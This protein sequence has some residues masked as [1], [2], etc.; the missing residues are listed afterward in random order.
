MKLF[1]VLLASSALWAQNIPSVWLTPPAP[2]PKPPA[3]VA[4]KAGR[5][6]DS[7]TGTMLRNQVILLRGER[8]TDVGPSVAIPAGAQVIDLSTA[9]VLPGLID[10]HLHVMDGGAPVEAY[11]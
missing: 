10:T 3:I 1:T 2:A 11:G 8:I 7:K 6:F 4:V 9:T 5:M